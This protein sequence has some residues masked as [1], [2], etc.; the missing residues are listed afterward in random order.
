MEFFSDRQIF[1]KR[2]TVYKE[3]NS[4]QH[5][6][7]RIKKRI[8][9]L[10]IKKITLNAYAE[11]YYFR[12]YHIVG[13]F[14]LIFTIFILYD[15]SIL[16]EITNIKYYTKYWLLTNCMMPQTEM[17]KPQSDNFG[18]QIFIFVDLFICFTM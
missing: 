18:P 17:I 13:H 11:T 6:K 5:L 16:E 7:Q 10:E 1:N 4:H 12:K 2:N 14:T 15:L 9:S 3:E 8:N